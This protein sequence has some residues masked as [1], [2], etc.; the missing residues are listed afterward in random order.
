VTSEVGVVAIGRN[1]GDRLRRCLNSLSRVRR[2]LVY[3]DSGSTDGS[4]ALSQQAGALVVPLDIGTPFTAA[5]AR[6]EGFKALLTAFPDTQYVFFVDGDCEVVDGWIEKAVQFLEGHADVALVWGLRRERH[7]ETS[8]YNH[9]CDLE[10]QAYPS[11]ETRAC[12]GDVVARVKVLREVGVF[13]PDLICGEEPE[14]CVRVRNAGWRIWRLSEAMTIHDAA[15][16]QFG[17]WWKRSVRT[18]YG[19][20]HDVSLHGSSPERYCVSETRRAWT[21]GFAIP[22]AIA[23][24]VSIFG[25]WALLALGVYPLQIWR[26]ARTGRH[27]ARDNWLW[28]SA[29][30]LSKFPEVLGQLR[31][32]RDRYMR[33][34][35]RLIEYK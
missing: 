22:V 24:L 19:Y 18:G 14:L 9:L 11:G 20:A 26:L 25:G 3:V 31:F 12:G 32:L 16:H 1:E 23:F 8:I 6:N 7:P 2:N 35:S 5:R 4:V 29:L 30:V 17:Q 21:W 10:W 15:M 34:R 13:R 27:G 28:A 33:I